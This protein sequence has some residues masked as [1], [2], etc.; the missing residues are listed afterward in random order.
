MHQ[1]LY[2]SRTKDISG[3]FLE[4]FHRALKCNASD[5]TNIDVFH[6]DYN[7]WKILSIT[8]EAC[9]FESMFFSLL[10]PGPTFHITKDG[11]DIM[12]GF[13]GILECSDARDWHYIFCH[14]I[15]V[16][17]PSSHNSPL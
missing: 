9:R 3:T 13:L 15:C 10:C 4:L 16:A 6:F 8:S 5:C 2:T 1:Y 17:S 7:A 12:E 11:C 14:L